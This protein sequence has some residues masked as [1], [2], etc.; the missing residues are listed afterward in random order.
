MLLDLNWF[1]VG[2]KSDDTAHAELQPVQCCSV[3]LV[4]TDSCP[5]KFCMMGALFLNNP[6]ILCWTCSGSSQASQTSLVEQAMQWAAHMIQSLHIHN[7]VLATIDLQFFKKIKEP[8]YDISLNIN[9]ILS[10][11][12]SSEF[13]FILYQSTVFGQA[14]LKYCTS[15]TGRHAMCGIRSEGQIS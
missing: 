8:T 7:C 11:L 12:S 10:S 5:N 13:A 1:P 3:M 15:L 6:V 4:L 2:Y 9:P 14:L